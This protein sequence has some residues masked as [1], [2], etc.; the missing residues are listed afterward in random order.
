MQA[1]KQAASPLKKK[2]RKK[3]TKLKI[4]TPEA[5]IDE[6]EVMREAIEMV[7]EQM[8]TEAEIS[9]VFNILKRKEENRANELL[10]SSVQKERVL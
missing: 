5:E 1:K 9:Y 10:K 3:G 6:Q 2:K 7:V 4:V 8:L